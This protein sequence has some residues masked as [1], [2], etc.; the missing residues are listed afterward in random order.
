MQVG[1]FHPNLT[2]LTFV[3]RFLGLEVLS[4]ILDYQLVIA[5]YNFLTF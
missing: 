3:I 4:L 2:L 5:L 1:R